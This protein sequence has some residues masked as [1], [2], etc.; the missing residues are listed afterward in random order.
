MNRTEAHC[1]SVTVSSADQSQN[2]IVRQITDVQGIFYRF[3]IPSFDGFLI[4]LIK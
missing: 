3:Q 4:F 2:L 1:Q